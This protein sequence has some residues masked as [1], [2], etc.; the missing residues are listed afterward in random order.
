MLEKAMRLCGAAFSILGTYDGTRFQYPAHRGILDSFAEYLKTAQPG[1]TG[2]TRRLIA[3][4]EFVEVAD[5]MDE[6]A[7][8]SGEGLRRALVELGGARSAIA[9]PLRK[10]D[11]LLGLITLYRQE[12]RPFS[13]KQIALLQN[14]AAQAVIAKGECAPHH[15]DT[16]CVGAA[17]RDRRGVAGH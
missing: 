14:F 11:V 8:R 1:P 4:A 5:L 10:D 7:Y 3:G 16:R 9:V 12:V 13:D 2:I 6:T 17:D 15:R